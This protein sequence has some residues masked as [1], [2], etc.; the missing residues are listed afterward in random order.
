MQLTCPD[1]VKKQK[2]KEGNKMRSRQRKITARGGE[3]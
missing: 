2:K 3:V 1:R